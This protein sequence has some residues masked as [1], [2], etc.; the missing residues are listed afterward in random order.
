MKLTQEK[1]TQYKALCEKIALVKNS[2][3]PSDFYEN[4]KPN[5]ETVIVASPHLLVLSL[6]YSLGNHDYFGCGKE[7]FGFLKSVTKSEYGKKYDTVLM[8]LDKKIPYQGKKINTYV[9]WLRCAVSQLLKE[10]GTL[11]GK[12]PIQLIPQLQDK[13]YNW[14]QVNK[15]KIHSDCCFVEIQKTK[16]YKKTL[17]EYSTGESI[18]IDIHKQTILFHYDTDD[19]EYVNNISEKKKYPRFTFSGSKVSDKIKELKDNAK[20]Q[21]KYGLVIYSNIPKLRVEKLELSNV[22]SGSDCY[23]FDN[24]EERDSYFEALKSKKVIALSKNLSYNQTINVKVQ[25][26]LMNPLIFNY[27]I[28]G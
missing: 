3:R 25:S 16:K 10:G 27:A 12:F 8:D 24:L 5:D 19:Y 4:L 15:I 17:I 1:Q 18:D 26:Y 14:F 2:V 6:I 28:S 21:N 13:D 11:K 22:T 23:L 7:D 9:E 20:K